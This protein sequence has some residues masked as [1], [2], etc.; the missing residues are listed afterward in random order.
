MNQRIRLIVLVLAFIVALGAVVNALPQ[1]YFAAALERSPAIRDA[2]NAASEAE[3]RASTLAADADTTGVE[4]LTV[5]H[6]AESATLG[7]TVA[8]L[9]L[10]R[11]LEVELAAWRQATQGAELARLRATLAQ[12]N[13]AAARKRLSAG[14]ISRAELGRAEGAAR[15][16]TS[17]VDE[18]ALDADAAERA[19]RLRAGALPGTNAASEPTPKLERAALLAV[20]ERTPRV[21]EARQRVERARIEV[22]AKDPEASSALEIEASRNALAA[23]ER[24]LSETR[25]SVRLAIIAALEALEAAVNATV[26]RERAVT[27]AAADLRAQEARLAR[28]A[29]SRLALL[30]SRIALESVRGTLAAARERAG[31]ALVDVAISANFDAW[32]R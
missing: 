2:R 27:G 17:A 18:A 31:L 3:R 23:A 25:D 28:G 4:L 9:S 8:R 7:L 20:L 21:V 10:R 11:S 30:E 15:E 14:V 24:G 26:G 13:L 32:A 19:L 16:A 12:G 6:A 29:I 22:D 1:G 5:R